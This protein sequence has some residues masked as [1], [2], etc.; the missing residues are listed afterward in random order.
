MRRPTFWGKERDNQGDLPSA[1]GVPDQ[2][3]WVSPFFCIPCFLTSSDR[4]HQ[5]PTEKLEELRR[6]SLVLTQSDLKLPPTKK[7]PDRKM[8]ESAVDETAP[9][10][11]I[12]SEGKNVA[13]A[14]DAPAAAPEATPA[15]SSAGQPSSAASQPTKVGR[16]HFGAVDFAKEKDDKGRDEVLS[17][18]D[19]QH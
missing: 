19:L 5:D 18:T 7:I 2:A 16:V 13:F 4:R 12:L 17:P 3:D 10:Q 11:H 15:S 1:D 6:H 14:E 9:V 8:P